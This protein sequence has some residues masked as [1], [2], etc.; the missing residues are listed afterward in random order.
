MLT[1]IFFF[2][3]Y[4]RPVNPVKWINSALFSRS[5]D[6]FQNYLPFFSK[7]DYYNCQKVS[8]IRR[9]FMRITTRGRYALRASLTMAAIAKDRSPV[10]ISAL[11][12][13]SIA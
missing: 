2:P 8:Y 3:T 13:R 12:D 5:Y 4:Q 10:A 1:H 6:F 9:H 7:I 11:A